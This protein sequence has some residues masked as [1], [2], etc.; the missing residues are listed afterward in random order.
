MCICLYLWENNK[1]KVFSEFYEGKFI[2]GEKRN[3][4]KMLSMKIDCFLILVWKW[5]T[6]NVHPLSTNLYLTRIMCTLLCVSKVQY[7]VLCYIEHIQQN[8][9]YNNNNR[10]RKVPS[11]RCTIYI[12][13]AFANAW[14][15]CIYV[16]R[17]TTSENRHWFDGRIN[18]TKLF[19]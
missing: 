16:K 8:T 12:E 6:Q 9:T 3:C 11:S 4:T 10:M 18:Y 13:K 14:L 17:N 7:N 2:T 19:E 15:F 1:L 5:N